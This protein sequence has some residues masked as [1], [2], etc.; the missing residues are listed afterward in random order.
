MSGDPSTEN[1]P[2]GLRPLPSVN[3]ALLPNELRAR[4][5]RRLVVGAVVGAVVLGALLLWVARSVIPQ[6]WD[7]MEDRLGRQ[8]AKLAA[9]LGMPEDLVPGD[10]DGGIE[11]ELTKEQEL[12]LARSRPNARYETL[13]GGVPSFRGALLNAGLEAD[14]CAAVERALQHIVDF[15]RCRPE[16]TLIVERDETARLKRFEYHPSATEFVE[17]TRGEDGLF[18]AEQIRVKVERTPIARATSVETSIGDG[19][20]GIGLPAGLAVFFVEAFEGQI[21]FALQARKGDVFRII[22]DEERVDGEFLRYGRVH[23]LEYDGQRTGKVQAFYYQAGNSRGQF[24]DDSGRAMQGGWL[25]TPLRYERLSSRYNP[26]RFHPILK[27]TV[28]HLGVDYAAATGTP[29]WAAAD[30]RVKFAGRKGPN[31]NL[32]IIR[33]GGGFETAYAHLYRIKGG[34]RPGKLVKQRELI[35]F[36][37]STGRSTGPH[38]HFGL[39]KYKRPLDPLTELNGPGLRMATRDLPS[40]KNV[41]ADWQA[42]LGGIENV[43]KVVAGADEPLVEQVDEIMD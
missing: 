15:R 39:K 36:V 42:Q 8:D 38:L 14:E 33:H 25:R 34:I 4:R 1:E 30:G 21:N 6:T 32:V 2:S 17:V 19:L 7:W 28:P 41:I 40:Y 5:T 11:E 20:V 37:G 22:V 10:A 12:A 31:G 29:V 9:D 18:R 27:R 43:P 16:H 3:M 24:Y 23:A 13:F 26:R 35:G